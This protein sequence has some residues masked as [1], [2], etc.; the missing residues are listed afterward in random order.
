MDARLIN[1]IG[2]PFGK[3]SGTIEEWKEARGVVGAES[4]QNCYFY[5]RKFI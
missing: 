5:Y 1:K 4:V 2:V 3:K